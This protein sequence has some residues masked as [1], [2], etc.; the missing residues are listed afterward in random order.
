MT[1][2]RAYRDGRRLVIVIEDPTKDLES[3]VAAMLTGEIKSVKDLDEPKKMARPEIDLK[4]MEEVKQ[5]EAK[6]MPRKAAFVK[7]LEEETAK[8]HE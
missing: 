6:D 1:N 5:P 4:K 7:K 8:T 3:L 2:M